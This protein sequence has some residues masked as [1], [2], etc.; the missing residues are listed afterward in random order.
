MY[1]SFMPGQL[2]LD[3]EGKP[4]QA[5][6][7]SVKYD[8]HTRLYYWYGENKEYTKAGGTVWHWGVRL[9]TSRD[10]YNWEDKGVIIP[11]VPEDLS[12]PL[13]P[14][15][16][17]DRPHILYC[18]KTGKYVAWLKIMAGT[19]SQ[20]MSVLVAD[21][22]EGPY[23]YVRRVHFPLGMDSGDFD[24]VYDEETGK[25][26]IIFERPHFELICATLTEDFTAAAEEYSTHFSGP[27]PPYTREAPTFFTRSGKKYLL[28]SGTTGYFPNTTLVCSFDEFHGTYTDLGDACEGD[29]YHVSFNAQFTSVIRVPGTDLYI[30]CADRWLPF[31]NVEEKAEATIR[32]YE[33]IFRD[34]VPD[35]TPRT[36]PNPL[37]GRLTVCWSNTVESRYVWLPIRWDGDR[38][39]ITWHAEWRIED[40]V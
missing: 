10:L 37:S 12:D 21:R 35:T 15:Y 31:E 9:Y 39:V 33:Q 8:P 23:T 40:F 38:P 26:Y 17:M 27:H 19:V 5:H 6:G 4:I 36:D 20:F 3:T 11:P 24:L 16:C 2:W 7:F 30:A 14:T 13:H 18:P 32:E 28:T 29:T 22:L 34:Y 1:T 25:G